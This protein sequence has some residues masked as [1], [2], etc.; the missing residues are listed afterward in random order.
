MRGAICIILA[1][2]L[3]GPGDKQGRR[4]NELFRAGNYR[5]AADAYLVG[6][7]EI[8][9]DGPDETRAHLLNNLGAAL[10]R[11]NDFE[12]AQ[13]A[14]IQSFASAE[15]DEARARAAYNAGNAAFRQI[16]LQAAA[17]F[18]KQSLLTDP[19][20][21]S[22][23]YNFEFVSRLLKNQPQD[24]QQ[25]SNDRIEPSEY[26]KALKAQAEQL[27]ARRQYRSAYDLMLKGLEVDETVQA[28]RDFIG[29]IGEVANIDEI[30]A[31]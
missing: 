10:Y 16:N 22:A 2:L 31:K 20:D 5:E 19:N 6:I 7:E 13:P 11:L 21:E 12:T 18:Y 25:S 4:G 9:E 27:V 3:F 17:S 30:S 8:G 23:R 15:S 29:R 1:V 24:Q 14:F 26:A 28:Y